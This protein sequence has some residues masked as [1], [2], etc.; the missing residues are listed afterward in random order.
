MIFTVKLATLRIIISEGQILTRN[1]FKNKIACHAIERN[2]NLWTNWRSY[3]QATLELFT[4]RLIS[5][6]VFLNC[7]VMYSMFYS[8]LRATS[9][10]FRLI[11][12]QSLISKGK[13]DHARGAILALQSFI[14]RGLF[15]QAYPAFS[16]VQDNWRIQT[17]PFPNSWIE[18]IS[19]SWNDF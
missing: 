18:K 1:S 16:A 15:P 8:S 9:W 6:C 13:G 17:L 5:S 19:N 10:N 3:C 14:V 2:F 4:V 7:D 12:S 11:F